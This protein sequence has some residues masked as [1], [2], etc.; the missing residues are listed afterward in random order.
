MS[1]ITGKLTTQ[2][3]FFITSDVPIVPWSEHVG[4]ERTHPSYANLRPVWIRKS[5]YGIDERSPHVIDTVIDQQ[6]ANTTAR[7][8]PSQYW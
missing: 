1:I 7:L 4:M 3:V 5:S 6:Q 2:A 8:S